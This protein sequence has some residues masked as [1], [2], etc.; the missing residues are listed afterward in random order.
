MP[1]WLRFFGRSTGMSDHTQIEWTDA[2]WNPVTGCTK[3]SAGCKYCYAEREWRRLSANPKTRYYGREFGDMRCH[4]DVL[5]LPLRWRKPRRVFV[6]SMADLFHP[7]VPEEFIDK[8]FAVMAL[9]RTHTFQVLTKRPKRMLEY[10]LGMESDVAGRRWFY[11]SRYDENIVYSIEE[12]I[13]AFGASLD[14]R[15]PLRNVWIGVSVENQATADER[16]P[17]LLQIP[18]AV[19][20]VS[21]EPLLGP[22]DLSRWIPT[23]NHYAT[24]CEHCGWAGSSKS[25]LGQDEDVI[26]PS[27]G[28][29]MRGEDD[30]G[31]GWVIAGGETGPKE[32]TPHPDWFRSLR[33]QCAVAGVPF[34]F[35]Q[36]GECAPRIVNPPVMTPRGLEFPDQQIMTRVGKKAAGRLLDGRLHDAY[37]K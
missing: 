31:I 10:M 3:V 9:A 34:M 5:S 21:C 16:I 25:C 24:R 13:R 22:V 33:D 35:K 20:F 1:E 6:N 2:T 15:L 12:S 14:R 30:A 26:C 36:W 8:V 11:A 7:D 18:A 29:S 4:G 32:R 28:M 37:P 17:L 19:R 27:C 23:E